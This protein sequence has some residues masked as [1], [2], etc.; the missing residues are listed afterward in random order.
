MAVPDGTPSVPVALLGFGMW[1]RNLA[2]NFHALGALRLI[3]E[4]DPRR[5]EEARKQYPGVEV[6]LNPEE[7][8][9][10]ED[11][12]AVVIATPAATHFELALQA[13]Q[14]G[15]DVFVEKPLAL[16]VSEGE[17][18]VAEAKRRERVLLV[19]HVLEYHP[20]VKKLLQLVAEGE[21]GQIYY[22]YSNRLNWGRIRTEEN[23]L[24]SFAP[25]DV[26][27]MLRLLGEMPERVTCEVRYAL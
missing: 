13:L 15:K 14:A 17:K 24:W 9:K 19:G 22:I 21:L 2:R 18:L 3:C 27:I 11:I 8:F 16:S 4:P 20:A 12:R 26:A 7:A 10:R 23:A 25:H 6:A 5:A 1:G